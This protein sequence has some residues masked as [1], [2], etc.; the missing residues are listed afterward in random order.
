MRQTKTLGFQNVKCQ[1]NNGNVTK[2]L[3]RQKIMIRKECLIEEKNV[4]L[5]K[6]VRFSAELINFRLG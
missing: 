2:M 6:N 3:E 1:K 5:K 4:V